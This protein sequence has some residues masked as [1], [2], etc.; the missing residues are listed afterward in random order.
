MAESISQSFVVSFNDMVQH[1]AQQRNSRF[2]MHCL[3]HEGVH[4]DRDPFEQLH[5]T[6]SK[7]ITGD[8]FSPRA[9]GDASHVRRSVWK[10]DY[11]WSEGI[12]TQDELALNINLRMEYAKSAAMDYARRKD[13]ILLDALLGT[14]YTG[15]NGDVTEAFDTTAYSS[16]GHVIDATG[17]MTEAIMR[18]IR[19]AF[20]VSEEM[21]EDMEDGD[22]DAFCLALAPKAHSELLSET[23]TTSRDFYMDPIF[24]QMPLVNGRIPFFMG[25]RIRISNRLTLASTTRHNI[26]WHRDAVGCSVW[27]NPMVSIDKRPDLTGNPWQV[28]FNYSMGAVR[29]KQ[30]GVYR[31]DTSEA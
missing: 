2:A 20:D 14:S 3:M 15:K 10:R 1:L 17:G 29:L 7:E 25:F 24:G 5:S 16:G 19:E 28:A 23:Q 18:T 11:E 13:T 9:L 6:Q 22:R 21:L 12:K 4:G 31:V 30:S 27:Q 8:R 26:A